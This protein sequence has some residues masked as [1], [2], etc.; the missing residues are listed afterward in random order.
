MGQI[1]VTSFMNA[2]KCTPK[3]LYNFVNF[4]KCVCHILSKLSVWF[5]FVS[6]GQVALVFTLTLPLHLHVHLHF[7]KSKRSHPKLHKAPLDKH[8]EAPLV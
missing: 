1:C 5:K 2:P 3:I 6:L 4:T 7:L 8:F